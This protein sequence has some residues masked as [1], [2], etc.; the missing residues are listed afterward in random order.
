MFKRKNAYNEGDVNTEREPKK[1]V[2][3]ETER[4]R[5]NRGT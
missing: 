2:R 4:K 3:A 1:E 5:L